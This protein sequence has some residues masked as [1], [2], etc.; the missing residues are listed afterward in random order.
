M[1]NIRPYLTSDSVL[2]NYFS[3][4]KEEYKTKLKNHLIQYQKVLI[5]KLNIFVRL[6][7]SFFLPYPYLLNLSNQISILVSGF[8]RDSCWVVGE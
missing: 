5:L 8:D 3:K 1:E 4:L 2:E 6:L 7:I